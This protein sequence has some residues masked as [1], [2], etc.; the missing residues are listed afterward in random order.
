[1]IGRRCDLQA[2]MVPAAAILFA[3]LP[4]TECDWH[5]LKTQFLLGF[6]TGFV[7]FERRMR[8]W[9]PDWRVQNKSELGQILNL[10]RREADQ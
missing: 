3:A 4:K 2:E 10:F 6:S 5:S 9:K 7:E 8:S 1:M